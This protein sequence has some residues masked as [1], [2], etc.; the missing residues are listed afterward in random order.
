MA[1]NDRIRK[2]VK[3]L[4]S[5]QKE[6]KTPVE[7]S[8][9]QSRTTTYSQ[10]FKSKDMSD[11]FIIEDHRKELSRALS[12]FNMEIKQPKVNYSIYIGNDSY[13]FLNVAYSDDGVLLEFRVLCNVINSTSSRGN[14]Y[15]LVSA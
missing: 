2:V 6:L 9:A 3:M 1:L 4:F 12:L 7:P 10:L 14:V 8:I 11:L 15:T 13:D 5:I